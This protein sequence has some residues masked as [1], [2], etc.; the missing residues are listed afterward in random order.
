M[1]KLAP[2]S[3]RQVRLTSRVWPDGRSLHCLP[4]SGGS[5]IEVLVLSLPKWTL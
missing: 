1:F 2:R 4:A 5:G 3:L